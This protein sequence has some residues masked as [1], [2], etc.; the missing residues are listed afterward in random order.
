[1][2]MPSNMQIAASETTTESSCVLAFREL[3]Y[4]YPL[5]LLHVLG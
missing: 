1:M 3:Q 5:C 2:K 4:Y